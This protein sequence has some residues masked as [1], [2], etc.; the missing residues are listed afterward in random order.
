L[1]NLISVV[2]SFIQLLELPAV[3]RIQ[4]FK[5]RNGKNRGTEMFH[6]KKGEERRRMVGL[7]GGTGFGPGR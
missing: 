5:E 3:S 6:A 1:A 4:G 2:G 7:G